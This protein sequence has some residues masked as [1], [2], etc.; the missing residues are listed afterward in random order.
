MSFS[1]HSSTANVNAQCLRRESLFA[2]L[3]EEQLTTLS[4]AARLRDFEDGATLMQQGDV[5]DALYIIQTGTAD[6]VV[7]TRDGQERLI[8]TVGTGKPVGE[9]GLLTG[10][11]RTA[12]IRATGPV[13]AIVVPRDAFMA[14]MGHA[15]TAQKLAKELAARLSARTRAQALEDPPLS[16]LLFNNPRLAPMWLILRLWLAY[17][18]L[19]AGIPKLTDPAWMS[20]G[21]P[22]QGFW[23]AS[24]STTP[25]PV[26]AYDWY[27][28][29]IE[30]LL[31]GGH[32][33]WF[34]KVVA[35]SEV[36][37]GI[38]LLVGAL[39]GV[40]AAVGLIMNVNY[41]LA[42][43]A[44]TN[45]VLATVAILIVL[46]W[47]VAGWWGVDRWLLPR[48]TAALKSL[49]RQRPTRPRTTI[50]PYS[51]LLNAGS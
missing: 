43:S 20:T 29:F 47:K 4:A 30:M 37:V 1:V 34:A 5:A 46:A 26:I 17:Q 11:R 41:L 31:A 7:R 9:L 32:Y 51:P 35:F 39:T 45:P 14:A 38:A 48:L 44:S 28:A 12:T 6:V 49:E 50:D 24:L 33:V 19:S 27:R 13:A 2:D 3:S 16:R 36:G 18:W 42:G 23:A 40:A 15:H 21:G 22:L 8:D 25:R 10:D